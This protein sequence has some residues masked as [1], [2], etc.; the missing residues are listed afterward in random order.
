[1]WMR[2]L[3]GEPVRW[4]G[5]GPRKQA[6]GGGIGSEGGAGDANGGEGGEKGSGA[7]EARVREKEERDSS[8]TRAA[9]TPCSPVSARLTELGSHY[10]ALPGHDGL[11]DSTM[12][13]RQRVELLLLGG[14]HHHRELR[15]RIMP[16]HIQL[17]VSND[18]E[19][20]KLLDG[21][22]IASGGVELLPMVGGFGQT[23]RD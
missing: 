5:A 4:R 13:E 14:R 8:G 1:M 18:E 17:A 3:W 12:P 2:R 20:T 23:S 9:T 22:T 6:S 7:G 16:R 11:W 15:A 10:V 19:L 21:T